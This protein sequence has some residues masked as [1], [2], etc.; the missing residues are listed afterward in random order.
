MGA[1]CFDTA[2]GAANKLV[3]YWEMSYLEEEAMD[4]AAADYEMDEVDEDMY[5][6]GRMMGD[7][8]SDEDE[9]EYDHLVGSICICCIHRLLF[10]FY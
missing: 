2:F 1:N 7:T 3:K 10:M 6:A 9:D 5:F 8:E 4:Y